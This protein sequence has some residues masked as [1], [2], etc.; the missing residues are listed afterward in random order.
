VCRTSIGRSACCRYA[1]ICTRQPTLPATRMSAPVAD[2]AP[3]FAIPS[4]SA[5][6]GC[7]RLYSPA[8]PQ[9]ISPSGISRSASHP[10]VC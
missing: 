6:S 10:I 8:D 7:S 3:A 1:A 2:T 4:F 5:I 9:Q